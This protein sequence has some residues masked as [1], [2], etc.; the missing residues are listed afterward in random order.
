MDASISP[1]TMRLPTEASSSCSSPIALPEVSPTTRKRRRDLHAT[2]NTEVE[3]PTAGPS[4]PRKKRKLEV[5]VIRPPSQYSSPEPQSRDDV[6]SPKKLGKTAMGRGQGVEEEGEPSSRPSGYKDRKQSPSTVEKRN[7]V[8]VTESEEE[9]VDEE[10]YVE[11]S[12]PTTKV[13]PPRHLKRRRETPQPS[14]ELAHHSPIPKRRPPQAK[15]IA[16]APPR[17]RSASPNHEPRPKVNAPPGLFNGT[18]GK[19]PSKEFSSSSRGLMSPKRPSPGPSSDSDGTEEEEASRL[20][21][22]LNI[23]GSR[24]SHL[25]VKTRKLLMQEEEENTQEAAGIYPSSASNRSL[26]LVSHNQRAVSPELEP[27]PEPEPEPELESEEIPEPCPSKPAQRHGRPFANDIFSRLGVVPDTQAMEAQESLDEAP[28]DPSQHDLVS[29]LN[30]LRTPI[31]RSNGSSSRPGSVSLISKMKSKRKGKPKEFKPIPQLSPSVFRPYLPQEDEVEDF[32]S[33]EK[34]TRRTRP[35]AQPLTQDTI[36]DFTQDDEMDHFMD[37]DGG[38]QQPA[39]PSDSMHN[40][41]PDLSLGPELTP[42][43]A[44]GGLRKVMNQI[45]SKVRLI[46]TQKNRRA[47]WN[48]LLSFKQEEPRRDIPVSPEVSGSQELPPTSTT[49]RA[50]ADGVSQV[51]GHERSITPRLLDRTNM[52]SATLYPQQSDSGA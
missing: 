38:A 5:E 23:P 28:Y 18:K 48:H 11:Y 16:K 9:A 36:E 22:A 44:E 31:R 8:E 27:E 17:Q 49:Q 26:S 34:D 50:D 2:Y 6:V 39:E 45:L 46:D 12:V 41:G 13:G 15:R 32:S 1:S 35:G 40:N 7:A 24:P 25:T 10:E 43:G 33:P 51:R 29:D 20:F 52:I 3:V 21:K 37:W 19:G 30:V 42:P 47:E 4:R 14:P